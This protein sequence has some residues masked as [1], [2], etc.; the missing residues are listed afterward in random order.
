[1]SN[2]NIVFSM[3]LKQ[4]RLESKSKAKKHGVLLQYNTLYVLVNNNI[5]KSRLNPK[6]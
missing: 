3:F 1:M 4:I 2:D 6:S 5:V